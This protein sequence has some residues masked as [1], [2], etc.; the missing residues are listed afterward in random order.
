MRDDRYCASL[1]LFTRASNGDLVLAS[2][3]ERPEGHRPG[4]VA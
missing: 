4:E 3:T 1:S 2:Y